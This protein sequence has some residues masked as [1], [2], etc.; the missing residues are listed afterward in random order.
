MNE[1]NEA[2]EKRVEAVDEVVVKGVRQ[3]GASKAELL[4][5]DVEKLKGKERS[6]ANL[7]GARRSDE[8]VAMS[9]REAADMA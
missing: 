7:K 1:A 8:V 4:G 9:K 5:K 3:Y 2:L 6:M